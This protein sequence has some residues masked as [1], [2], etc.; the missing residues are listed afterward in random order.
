MVILHPCV[1][2]MFVYGLLLTLSLSPVLIENGADVN[3]T[4]NTGWTSLHF[5]SWEGHAKIARSL[6]EHGADVTA[7]ADEMFTPLTVTTWNGNQF[8]AQLLLNHGAVQD[9]PKAM[10]WAVQ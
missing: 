6:I 7:L 1:C 5:A 9:K 2:R 3:A 8:M 10:K 4:D